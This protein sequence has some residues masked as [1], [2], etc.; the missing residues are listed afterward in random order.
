MIVTLFNYHV[1]LPRVVLKIGLYEVFV[2]LHVF[3][4]VQCSGGGLSPSIGLNLG[5]KLKATFV[6]VL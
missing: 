5:R 6:I 2:V 3:T 4:H 1:R